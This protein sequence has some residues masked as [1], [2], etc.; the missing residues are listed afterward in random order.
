[1][2]GSGNHCQGRKANWEVRKLRNLPPEYVFYLS[3]LLLFLIS[4]DVLT[5]KQETGGRGGGQAA[6]V[7]QNRCG[8]KTVGLLT[9]EDARYLFAYHAPN[10]GSPSPLPFPV[11]KNLIE[12]NRMNAWDKISLDSHIFDRIPTAGVVLLVP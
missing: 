3:I 7:S 2:C 11:K 5:A 8:E 1:M 10:D 12:M 4:P 6:A 9:K